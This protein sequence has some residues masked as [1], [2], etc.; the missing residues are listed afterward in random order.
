MK[1]WYKSKTLWFNL[2]MASLTAVEASFSLFEYIVPGNIYV[3]IVT[4]LA[5]GNAVLRVI[6]DSKLIK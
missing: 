3:I 5:I 1:K 6:S 4:S 2:L